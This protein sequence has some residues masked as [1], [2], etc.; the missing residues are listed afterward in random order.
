[1]PLICREAPGSRCS[2]PG[3]TS[4]PPGGGSQP[5]QPSPAPARPRRFLTTPSAA[6]PLHSPARLALSS[7][8]ACAEPP[9]RSEPTAP[10]RPCSAPAQPRAPQRSQSQGPRRQLGTGTCTFNLHLIQSTTPIFPRICCLQ[11]S[12]EPSVPAAP[13][14]RGPP[15]ALKLNYPELPSSS[16]L[17]RQENKVIPTT[18]GSFPG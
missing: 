10:A 5:A 13:S 8:K 18:H 1:M 14:Q 2:R 12:M 3:G 4:A 11:P 7:A 9:A 17:S 16:H 15:A 6:Q